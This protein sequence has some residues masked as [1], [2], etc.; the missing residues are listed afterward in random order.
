MIGAIIG[1]VAGLAGSLIGAGAQRRAA[2][3]Q[4]KELA[5]QRAANEAWYKRNYYQDYLNTVEAQN[6]LKRVENAW[7]E[8]TREARAR[9]AVA[10]GTP[11]QAV[12]VAEA[13]GE[14]MGDMVGNLAAQGAQNKAAIDAQKLQMD[15]N[16]SA[17]ESA[18]AEAR[19]QAGA[20]LLS[21]G[22]GV[23]ASALQGMDLKAKPKTSIA[24]EAGKSLGEIDAKPL[25]GVELLGD[26]DMSVPNIKQQTVN[27]PN[28]IVT[29][30]KKSA[31]E[32]LAKLGRKQRG[33]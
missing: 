20:N 2:R 25:G 3:K 6:A 15:A 7:A 16:I 30:G 8:R 31:E 4:E 19:E 17:Q 29:P 12:A 24:V 32:E 14:A 1:G 26:V 11:E 10:G 13:G 27:I 5:K 23:A 22:I 33:Y 18:L 21:N 9:Q 28:G